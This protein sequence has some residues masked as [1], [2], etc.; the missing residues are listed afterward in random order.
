[1][2]MPVLSGRPARALGAHFQVHQF[3]SAFHVTVT[4]P[5]LLV[6]I[7][8]GREWPERQ[9]TGTARPDGKRSYP[10]G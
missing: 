1:M 5:S 10:Y 4:R 2:A 3:P 7:W 9:D 8:A 6:A